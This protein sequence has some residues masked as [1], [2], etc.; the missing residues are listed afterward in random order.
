MKE[1]KVS[2]RRACRVIGQPRATQRYVLAEVDDFERRLTARILELKN[3]EKYRRTGCRKIAQKLNNEGWRVN[4]KRVHRVW[5]ELGLQVPRQQK[6]RR[7]G[8]GSS[9]KNACD[10]LKPEL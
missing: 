3:M 2:E 8:D 9:F 1:F 10:R 7:R 4:R 6:K 5:K